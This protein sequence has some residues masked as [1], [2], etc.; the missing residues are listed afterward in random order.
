VKV[1][2]SQTTHNSSVYNEDVKGRDRWVTHKRR[3]IENAFYLQ[4]Q[5]KEDCKKLKRDDLTV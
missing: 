2:H 3:A 4:E 1:P 5:S